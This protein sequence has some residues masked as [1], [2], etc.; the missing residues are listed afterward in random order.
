MI[1]RS[2]SDVLTKLH[3]IQWSSI[4]M[5]LLCHCVSITKTLQSYTKNK[6]FN[7]NIHFNCGYFQIQRGTDDHLR[8]NLS[9]NW[10]SYQ[11]VVEKTFRLI[12]I[13]YQQ[14]STGKP[15]NNVCKLEQKTL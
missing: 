6:S 3:N 15:V 12:Q 14:R 2:D 1:N 9:I 10:I 13:S 5:R 7:D 8:I 11:I 4:G